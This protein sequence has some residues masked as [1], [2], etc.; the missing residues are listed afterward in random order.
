M[1]TGR[2]VRLATSAAPSASALIPVGVH[3]GHMAVRRIGRVPECVDL[4]A[5]GNLD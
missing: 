3:C 4:S 1:H 2:V 5:C